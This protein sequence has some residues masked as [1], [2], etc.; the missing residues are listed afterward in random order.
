MGRDPDNFAVLSSADKARLRPAEHPEWIDP[1]LATLTD[2]RFSDKAWIFERKLDGIRCLSFR[3]GNRVR[4][5]SRKKLRLENTYPEI[6]D[7][8][9][10]QLSADFVI[11]GEVVAFEQGRTSFSLLQQ[12]SGITDPDKAR[13]SP[14]RVTYY[15]FD[16]MHLDG[17][18]TRYL[19]LRARKQLLQG[20]FSYASP[21]KRTTH[22]NADGEKYFADAC[23]RG[24][25]GVIAKR[26]DSTYS[27]SRS[28]NWLKFKCSRGQEFVIGGYTDPGGT[29]IGFG[30][31]LVGYYEGDRF[32]YAGKVG[33]GFDDKILKDLR[34]RLAAME[35]DRSPFAGHR[36]FERG[37]H[38]VRPGLVGEVGFTEWTRDG[39]LRHPR[40]LGLR[41]DKDAGEVVRER[42]GGTKGV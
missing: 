15:V 20:A 16:V 17:Q 13:R 1:M 5:L 4:L 18:D 10:L 38:F 24:W 29:R 32:V 11:D 19:P 12:R 35:V 7:Q 2:K 28:P 22:R 30:A 41:Q 6:A 27:S 34:N 25:E 33:T 3:E 42:T 14:V 39:L 26:A 31:L 37:T 8:I 36:R 9:A 21:L 23:S 40:F